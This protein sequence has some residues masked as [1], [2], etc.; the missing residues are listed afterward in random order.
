MPT[1]SARCRSIAAASL[2]AVGV[3]ACGGGGTGAVVLTPEQ[4]GGIYQICSLVFQPAGP[5]RPPL[6][7][8]AA[9]MDTT[10]RPGLPQ[11]QVRLSSTRYEFVLEFVPPGDF[12]ERRFNHT[13]RTGPRTVAL[14]FPN[15]VEAMS[16]LLLPPSLELEYTENPRSL[17]VTDV[18]REHRVPRADYQRLA[19]IQDPNLADPVIGSLTG[20]FRSGGCN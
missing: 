17:R 15:P 9:V 16:A 4:V 13:F 6:D 2:F 1:L 8:R 5:G 3:S 10:P 7:L 20:V 12:V 18:F 11:P 19:G 14:D